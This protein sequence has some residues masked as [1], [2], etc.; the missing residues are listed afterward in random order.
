MI[1]VTPLRRMGAPDA[2]AALVAFLASPAA[3]YICGADILVDGEAG[4]TAAGG[5]L[6]L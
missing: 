4:D 1:A 2:I 5:V 3:T 6:R